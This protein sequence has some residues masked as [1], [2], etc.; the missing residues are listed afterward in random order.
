MLDG[1]IHYRHGYGR[2]ALT[3][4]H[5]EVVECHPPRD[6]TLGRRAREL[7]RTSSGFGV[8]LAWTDAND[9]RAAS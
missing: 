9:T 6:W 2:L 8:D 4:R 1:V 5:G 7:W 3:V